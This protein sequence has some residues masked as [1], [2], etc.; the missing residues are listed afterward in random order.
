MAAS[1]ERPEPLMMP[2]ATAQFLV[3]ASDHTTAVV[4]SQVH[5]QHE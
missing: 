5:P 2:A 3:A 4:F 1:T